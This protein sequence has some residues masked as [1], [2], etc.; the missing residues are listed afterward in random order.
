MK[1]SIIGLDETIGLEVDG[2]EQRLRLCAVRR[3]LPPLLIIQGGPGLPLLNEVP[4]FHSRLSLEDDFT[5]AYCDQRGCGPAAREAV[6]RG[7]PRPASGRSL[8]C[9]ASPACEDGKKDHSARD[10]DRRDPRHAGSRRERDIVSKVVA[11]SPDL[12]AAASNEYAY[13]ILNNRSMKRRDKRMA[14]ILRRLG[15]APLHKSIR[16]SAEIQTSRDK[17]SI[18]RGR[19]FGGMAAA[20]LTSLIRCYGPAGAVSALRLRR[21]R[22]ALLPALAELRLFDSWPERQLPMHL[23][24]GKIVA[25]ADTALHGGGGIP[26]AEARRQ[27]DR[28]A[29]EP[30]IW[31]TSI[32]PRRWKE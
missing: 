26:S 25:V 32:I 24:C 29:F 9:T 11:I 17:G 2:A 15:P 16:I 28:A 21:H 18:E 13:E 20:H 1:A 3:G 6:D 27:S 7:R 30:D 23:V 31:S 8:P 14:G 12:D 4:R 5:V 19:K 10:I 22:E